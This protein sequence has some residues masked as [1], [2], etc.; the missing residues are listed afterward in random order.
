MGAAA[1]TVPNPSPG[2]YDGSPSTSL[3]TWTSNVSVGSNNPGNYT[4]Y[5]PDISVPGTLAQL[6]AQ[7]YSLLTPGGN[8]SAA[9]ISALS[10]SPA[11]LQLAQRMQEIDPTTTQAQAINWLLSLQTP[12][13]MGSVYYIWH[14]TSTPGINGWQFTSTANP[15]PGLHTT[16]TPNIPGFG[17]PTV[18]DGSVQTYFQSNG[19]NP[20]PYP[21]IGYTVNPPFDYSI[22]EQFYTAFNGALDP[23]GCCSGVASGTDAAYWQPSSGYQNVL[24]QLTFANFCGVSGQS[25]GGSFSAPD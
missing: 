15:P 16:I 22:H 13:P 17:T 8:L 7:V 12:I 24:G 3:G 25:S 2:P 5:T 18:P 10:S 11:V 14:Q 19:S 1:R 21:T 6:L 23:P 4:I 20:N 9:D